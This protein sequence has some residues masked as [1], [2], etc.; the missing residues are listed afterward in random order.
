MMMKS[1]GNIV[2][3]SLAQSPAKRVVTVA[4][5]MMSDVEDDEEKKE[6]HYH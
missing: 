1:Y 4:D 5:Y 6:I 3:R 2:T